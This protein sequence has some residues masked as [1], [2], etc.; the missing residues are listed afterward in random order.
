MKENNPPPLFSRTGKTS[1]EIVAE[2]RENERLQ[3]L[4]EMIGAPRIPKWNDEEALNYLY[5]LEQN[6]YEMGTDEDRDEDRI[7]R[8]AEDSINMLSINDEGTDYNREM[9][10]VQ[11]GLSGGYFLE[12]GSAYGVTQPMKDFRNINDAIVFTLFTFS[13]SALRKFGIAQTS[14]DLYSMGGY[15]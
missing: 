14:R 7:E 6:I 4:A 12:E 13:K 2:A 5:G 8:Y 3:R 1:E 10:F 15:L 11:L 9:A